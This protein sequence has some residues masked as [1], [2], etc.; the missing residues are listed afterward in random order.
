METFYML[1]CLRL[2]LGGIVFKKLLS[3]HVGVRRSDLSLSVN[4]FGQDQKGQNELCALVT[5]QG[6]YGGT[7]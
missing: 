7:I 2:C 4:V 5:S 1:M 6:D 3:M